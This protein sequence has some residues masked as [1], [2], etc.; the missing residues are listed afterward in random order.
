MKVNQLE[1][2][3][4]FK[5][6]RD[7]IKG[8]SAFD[9]DVVNIF[10]VH[11]YSGDQG[12]IIG[13]MK[14]GEEITIKKYFMS[15]IEAVNKVRAM[16]PESLGVF[17]ENGVT[18]ILFDVVKN[19]ILGV[20][21]FYEIFPKKEGQYCLALSDKEQIPYLFITGDSVG[22]TATCNFTS[23]FYVKP[24]KATF[25]E[26]AK[27]FIYCWVCETYGFK[28]NQDAQIR[29]VDFPF[30]PED[31]SSTPSIPKENLSHLNKIC[32][33]ILFEEAEPRTGGY[34]SVTESLTGLI[35]SS[36][37]DEEEVELSK[38]VEIS[39]DIDDLEYDYILEATLINGKLELVY[40]TG[41][42]EHLI[43]KFLSVLAWRG[44][45]MRIQ[46]SR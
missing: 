25:T 1:V 22:I 18:E 28:Y 46:N 24:L 34:C 4:D 37:L 15:T 5:G 41:T 12:N 38:S 13:L 3:C 33:D 21:D 35:T 42:Q 45:T 11:F 36:G 30:I 29:L 14:Y 10:P 16:L 39:I 27:K 19:K 2:T 9:R 31:K 32:Q 26:T 40:K 17:F 7:I 6:E 8:R 23:M 43:Q 20:E 44:T